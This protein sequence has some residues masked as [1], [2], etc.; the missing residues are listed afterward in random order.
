MEINAIVPQI[1]KTGVFVIKPSQK[2][3]L[4]TFILG[5]IVFLVVTVVY[6]L[7]KQQ[8]YNWYVTL[9][10]G[11]ILAFYFFAKKLLV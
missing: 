7:V 4:F 5:V 2:D 1:E 11:L 8:S 6:S 10:L 9:I 3:L